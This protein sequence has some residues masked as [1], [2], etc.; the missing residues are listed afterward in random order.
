MSWYNEKILPHLIDHVSSIEPL[1]KQRE[2]VVPLASGRVL[3][4]GFG[5]GLNM[6]YYDRARVEKIFALDPFMRLRERTAE[7]IARS[8]LD[9]QLVQ[10]GAESIPFEDKTFDTVLMT[11][12][13]CSI[14]QPE[15]ALSEIRRVLK[16]GGRLV[17]CEHGL[18]PE[19]NVRR[20]Q[21]ALNPCWKSISGGCHL[22]REV[23]ALLKRASFGL[24]GL[25][26]GYI[27]TISV[28]SFNYWGEAL[29]QN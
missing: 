23:P 27:S 12:T 15:E 4:V 9:V 28:V 21:H 5:T 19:P 7:R 17:F 16:T 8:G 29:R 13:L 10:A 26:T 1:M 18:A 3:E 6:A 11:Y 20:W 22:D 25:R 14:P 24:E 2:R